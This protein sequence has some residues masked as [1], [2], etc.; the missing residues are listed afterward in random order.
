MLKNENSRLR[1]YTFGLLIVSNPLSDFMRTFLSSL[2]F[3]I[4]VVAF[5]SCKK[6]NAP[7]RPAALDNVSPTATTT[8]DRGCGTTTI[9]LQIAAV[10]PAGYKPYLV[11]YDQDGS[12]RYVYPWACSNYGC[13]ASPCLDAADNNYYQ[14]FTVDRC[15]QIKVVLYEID[16]LYDCNN[17]TGNVTIRL[18]KP[19]QA[20]FVSKTLTYSGGSTYPSACFNIDS[21]GNISGPITCL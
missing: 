6:D 14:S 16:P 18:K 5:S 2:I 17:G 7:T 19:N 3:A 13:T 4:V 15:E 8:S 10:N 21:N 1:H 9:Q 11:V 20:G 12:T